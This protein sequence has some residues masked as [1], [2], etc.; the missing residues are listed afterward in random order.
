MPRPTIG[1]I[2]V[3]HNSG[4]FINEWLD[5]LEAQSYRPDRVILVDSGST[6][7]SFLETVAQSKL[8]IEIVREANVGFSVGNNIGWRRMRDL[9]YVLFLNPDAFLA[10]NFLELAVEYMSST[11]SVGLV[12]PSLVRYDIA[13][14]RPLDT[15]D[16]T[17]VIRNRFGLIKER[18]ADLP[19]SELAR[20]TKPNEVPW[21]CAAVALARREALEAVVEHGNQIFD[22]SFFMYKEDTDLA[23]RIRRAGWLN[24]HHPALRGFH[25]RGWQSRK[26]MSRKAKL[27]TARNEVKMCIKNRSP[28]VVIGLLKFFLVK[29]LDR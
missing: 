5:A 9:D 15:I 20:Y 21:V 28:Y 27:L 8:S 1:I 29:F 2:T 10:P 26:S 7:P 24:M 22:E 18:D 23:W 4:R 14:H 13:H 6:E 12:T 17:G 16:T 19:I 3:T 11:P 25:C